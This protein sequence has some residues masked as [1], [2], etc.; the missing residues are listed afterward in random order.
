MIKIWFRNHRFREA[1][2]LDK[3][4]LKQVVCKAMG[5]FRLPFLGKIIDMEDNTSTNDMLLVSTC[6]EKNKKGERIYDFTSN[7]WE[8]SREFTHSLSCELVTYIDYKNHLCQNEYD[9]TQLGDDELDNKDIGKY[10]VINFIL[11]FN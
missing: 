3:Q 4:K 6:N 9:V 7:I 11:E 2:A 5:M 10:F 8:K 1:H